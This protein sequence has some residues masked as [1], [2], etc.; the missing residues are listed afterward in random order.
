MPLKI[1][2]DQ[3]SSID[4]VQ[5]RELCRSLGVERKR[6]TPYHPEADGMAERNIGMVKQV[7]RC[8][9]LDLRLS[10]ES[11]PSLL[12]EV[13]FHCNGMKNAT[14]STS[15]QMLTRGQ[16]PKCPMDTWCDILHEGEAN[17]H[18][19]YL[20]NLKAKQ[21]T[22]QKIAQENINRSLERVRISRNIGRT[23]SCIEVGDRVMLKRNRM[24]PL[25]PLQDLCW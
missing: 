23:F 11:W 9:Q 3:G 4:G 12:T 10:K 14:S 7:I 2:S 25:E 17:S 8:L 20:R 13:S 22:L 18:E 15:P 5:F 6:I 1:L 16:Q 19:E 24:G 21:E